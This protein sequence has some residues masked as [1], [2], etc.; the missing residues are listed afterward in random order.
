MSEMVFGELEKGNSKRTTPMRL[1]ALFCLTQIDV[2]I[3]LD[4]DHCTSLA[5]ELY[6]CFNLEYTEWHSNL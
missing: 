3:D 2:D 5:L 1:V 6:N 4:L